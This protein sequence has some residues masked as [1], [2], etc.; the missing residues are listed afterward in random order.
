ML[1]VQA[2]GAVMMARVLTASANAVSVAKEL[3]GDDRPLGALITMLASW[4]QPIRLAAVRA[5]AKIT[6]LVRLSSELVI[7]NR[8]VSQPWTR[9]ADVRRNSNCRGSYRL[10]HSGGLPLRALSICSALVNTVAMLFLH[11]SKDALHHTLHLS[12]EMSALR[13]VLSGAQTVHCHAGCGAGQAAADARAR[14]QDAGHSRRQHCDPQP[15][16]YAGV[17]HRADTLHRSQGMNVQSLCTI[18]MSSLCPYWQI[19]QVEWLV[20][21]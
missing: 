7:P 9:D 15:D 14:F 16:G 10:M 4:E 20:Q 3:V 5:L 21:H 1:L 6:W 11:A 19:L 12:P 2:Y 18:Q 17:G 13:L 8:G